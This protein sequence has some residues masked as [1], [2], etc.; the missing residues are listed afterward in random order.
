[1]RTHSLLYGAAIVGLFLLSTTAIAAETTVVPAS[2]AIRETATASSV[3]VIALPVQASDLGLELLG[4]NIWRFVV[5]APKSVHNMDLILE[6]EEKGGQA[7][8]LTSISLK[9]REEWPA[10]GRLTVLVAQA[11]SGEDLKTAARAKYLVQV[12]GFSYAS[13]DKKG[14]ITRFITMPDY[15]MSGMLLL[16]P[17]IRKSSS[18]TVFHPSDL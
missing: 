15:G 12:N 6:V 2:Y 17:V 18:T 3:R 14:F 7:R 4:P 5:I 16:N 9:Q 10:N 13:V 11:V 8:I 1:M